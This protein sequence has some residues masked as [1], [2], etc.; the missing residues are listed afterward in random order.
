VVPEGTT[1]FA[2]LTGVS[3]NPTSLHTMEVIVVTDGFGLT[4]TSTLK[5]APVQL[6]EEGVTV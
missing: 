6:P 4:V 5:S 2:I 3:E 1:P